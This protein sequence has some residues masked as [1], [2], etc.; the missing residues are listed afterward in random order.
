[1]KYK[2]VETNNLPNEIESSLRDL[3][4]ALKEKFPFGVPRNRIGEATGN[5]LHPRT[6]AN[7]DSLGIGI[8]ERSRNV[9]LV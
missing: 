6:C 9:Q 8:P 5:I 2:N 1:M 4:N 3:E 7:E